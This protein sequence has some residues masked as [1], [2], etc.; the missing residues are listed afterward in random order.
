MSGMTV[1]K[2]LTLYYY[3]TSENGAGMVKLSQSN[4]RTDRQGR[5]KCLIK[6]CMDWIFFVIYFNDNNFDF[7]T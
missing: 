4:D 5:P 1:G 3:Y 2:R 7:F 6:L